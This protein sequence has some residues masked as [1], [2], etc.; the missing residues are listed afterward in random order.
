MKNTDGSDITFQQL[1]AIIQH[2][3]KHHPLP[4]SFWDKDEAPVNKN[5]QNALHK[6][7]VDFPNI[8]QPKPFLDSDESKAPLK[9]TVENL[10]K[11]MAR[12]AELTREMD[13][14]IK[15]LRDKNQRLAARLAKRGVQ[16]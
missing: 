10:Q 16:L 1:V 12:D 2:V 7:M 5:M 6:L 8:G 4:E 3:I 9:Q 13:R 11:I 14:E 15:Q